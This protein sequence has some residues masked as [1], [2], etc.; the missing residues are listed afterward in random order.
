[1][2]GIE[3]K[4]KVKRAQVRAKVELVEGRENEL[5]VETA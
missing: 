1:M 4:I 5:L 2:N 3:D